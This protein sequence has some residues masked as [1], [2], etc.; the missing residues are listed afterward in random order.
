MVKWFYIRFKVVGGISASEAFVQA[1]NHS[2]AVG[3][4]YQWLD[5]DLEWV[6]CRVFDGPVIQ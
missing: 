2:F 6:D 1:Q 3:M 5:V 4:L